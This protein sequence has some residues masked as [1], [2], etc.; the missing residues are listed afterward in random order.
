MS[1]KDAI[2]NLL[3]G[4][5]AMTQGELAEAV[6]GDKKHMPNIYSAL[7]SLV[8]DGTVIR[9]GANPSYYSLGKDDIPAPTNPKKNS[10]KNEMFQEMSFLTRALKKRHVS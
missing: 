4:S 2:I 8:R 6:Y 3:Q 7:Q 10:E 5:N 9:N 1:Q